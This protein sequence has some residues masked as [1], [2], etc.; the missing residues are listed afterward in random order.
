MPGRRFEGV[1]DLR[2]GLIAL[3]RQR[4]SLGWG[5]SMGIIG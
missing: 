5:E 4:W 1:S 2:C 3:Y